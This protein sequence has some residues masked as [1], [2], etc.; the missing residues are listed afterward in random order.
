[1]LCMGLA[2]AHVDLSYRNLSNSLY[3]IYIHDQHECISLDEL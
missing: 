2:L 1:M 3:R